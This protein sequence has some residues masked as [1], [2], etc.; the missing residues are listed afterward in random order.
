[1]CT[2]SVGDSPW[3]PP[4]LHPMYL[5]SSRFLWADIQIRMAAKI[6]QPLL[7]TGWIAAVGP[8]R[9]IANTCNFYIFPAHGK[10]AWNAPKWGRELFFLL[11]Q[12]LPTFWATRI[13]I[14]RIFIFFWKMP[15]SNFSDSLKQIGFENAHPMPASHFSNSRS[16]T[17]DNIGFENAPCW[18]FKLLQ[19]KEKENWIWEIEHPPKIQISTFSHS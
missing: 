7:L 1:M 13:L 6:L 9:K 5:T 15:G 16:K 14:L 19:K 12:T 10:I 11:I 8:P 3:E 17:N 2:C 18:C 4:C